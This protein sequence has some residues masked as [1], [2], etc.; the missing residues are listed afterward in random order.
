MQFFAKY[1]SL[2]A[3]I[4]FSYFI[5]KRSLKEAQIPKLVVLP[6]TPGSSTSKTDRHDITEIFLKVVLNNITLTL[7]VTMLN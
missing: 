6:G 2:W 1:S 7:I 4:F 3:I 5:S